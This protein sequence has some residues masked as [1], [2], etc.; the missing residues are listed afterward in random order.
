MVQ[1][2]H[3]CSTFAP[4]AGLFRSRRSRSP[5]SAVV[6][7]DGAVRTAPFSHTLFIRRLAYIGGHEIAI[8]LL[9]IVKV[10]AASF[11]LADGSKSTY[12]HRAFACASVDLIRRYCP[13]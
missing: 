3:D 6:A 11:A 7:P 2:R 9:V 12:R 10:L 4:I 1:F 13:P 5:R 8:V